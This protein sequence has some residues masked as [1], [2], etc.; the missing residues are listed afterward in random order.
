MKNKLKSTLTS[1]SQNIQYKDT[2]VKTVW[3]WQKNRQ[4]DH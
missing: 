4:I 3:H 2:G 1:Q